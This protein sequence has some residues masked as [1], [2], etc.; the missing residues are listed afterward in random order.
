M[1][2]ALIA[3]TASALMAACLTAGAADDY[4]YD[5]RFYITPKISYG[6]LDQAHHTR[7]KEGDGLGYGIAIGKPINK[8]WNLE[9]Y[10]FNF[11]D[12]E[13][14]HG[15][16]QFDREGYGLTALYFPAPEQS[17]V[18]LLAGYAVGTYEAEGT[19]FKT[20]VDYLDLGYG[21]MHKISEYGVSIRVE[22]RYRNTDVDGAS[23]DSDNHIISLSLQIPIGAPPDQS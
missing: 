10:Y 22:Y 4:V 16:G 13:A 6:F 15:A 11:A 17:R 21:Y 23:D 9:A 5:G 18:F 1:Q 7:L 2:K 8:Y 3:L 20:E 14:E 19:D 12:I